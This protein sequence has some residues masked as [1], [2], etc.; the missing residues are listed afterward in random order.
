MSNMSFN[1]VYKAWRNRAR[2][3]NLESIDHRA[4][5]VLCER[6]TDRMRELEKAPW[7]T[8]LMV[9]WVCQDRHPPARQLALDHSR[10]VRRPAPETLGVERASGYGHGQRNA[11]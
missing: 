3:Y 6:E 2:K 8:M 4:L 7:L 10:A 11:T 1:D 5:D 9:K